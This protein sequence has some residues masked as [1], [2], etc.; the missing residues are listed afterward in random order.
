MFVTSGEFTWY[1]REFDKVQAGVIVT[2][3]K[4]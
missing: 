4:S 2:G 3:M 1:K